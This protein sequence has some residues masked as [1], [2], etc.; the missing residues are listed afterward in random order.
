MNLDSLNDL[1][2]WDDDHFKKFD[3]AEGEEWKP[4]PTRDAAKALYQQWR[5]VM[6]ML[7]GAL[8]SDDFKEDNSFATE[9][10]AMVMGDAFEVGAKIRSSET[11]S[12]YILKM[13]NAAVI[14]KNAQFVASSLLSFAMQNLIEEKYAEAIRSEIDSFRELFKQWV[15]TFQKDEFEDEWGLF[16]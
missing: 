15:S 7:Q 2:D 9:Q 6:T 8:D 4:N 16:I 5:Q 12:L 14:R 11:G 13:E 10:C 3:D 1:P